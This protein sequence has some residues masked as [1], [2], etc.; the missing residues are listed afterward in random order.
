MKLIIDIP[1]HIYE[2]ARGRLADGCDKAE[3]MWAIA[4]GSLITSCNDVISRAIVQEEITKSI[5][6]K[7]NPYQL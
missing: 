7:E 3:A 1:E 2:H 4:N 6:L 5:E